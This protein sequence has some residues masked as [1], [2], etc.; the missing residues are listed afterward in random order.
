MVLDHRP[1]HNMTQGLAL[2]LVQLNSTRWHRYRLDSVSA[3]FVKNQIFAFTCLINI[4][5]FISGNAS[6][7]N[8]T[9]GL[10]LYYELI[11]LCTLLVYNHTSMT[12]DLEEYTLN[13]HIN[14]YKCTCCAEPLPKLP[15][16]NIEL[17]KN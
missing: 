14:E 4:F 2:C 12:V 5:D 3:L 15:V 16:H 6:Q 7:Q 17:K 1:V 13:L 8:T 10:V 9:Q 11:L